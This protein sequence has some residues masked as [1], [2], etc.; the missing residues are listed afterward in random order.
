MEQITLKA[1]AKINLCLDI[2]GVRSNGYHQI[3]TIM[4]SV[5]LYDTINV[6]LNNT[7]KIKVECSICSICDNSNIALRAAELFLQEAGL[8]YGV[9]ICIEKNIPLCG[10]LGGGSA[11][12]AAVLNALNI[13]LDKP[14]TVSQLSAIGLT[15]GADVPFCIVGGTK[16]CKGIGEIVTDAPEFKDGCFVLL[17]CGEKESTKQMY[18]TIDTTPNLVRPNVDLLINALENNNRNVLFDNCKNVF[19][20]CYSLENIQRDVLNSGADVFCLSGS[21]SYAYALLK[22]KTD[23]QQCK[24]NLQSIGYSAIV[25][26]PKKCGFEVL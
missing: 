7:G 10:G 9:D 22:N 25:C 21:G 14:F 26:E 11:D 8:D 23:A 16:R 17:N 13:L 6:K 2:T 5:D 15:L 4:Q 24:E 12:A 18:K 19:S 20:S 3:D 1:F